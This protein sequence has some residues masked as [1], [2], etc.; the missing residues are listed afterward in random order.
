MNPATTGRKLHAKNWNIE[1]IGD[2]RSQLA[3]NMS[4]GATLGSGYRHQ[5]LKERVEADII[6]DELL[7]N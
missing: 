3:R 6:A 2:I 5:N 7:K 4:T 1:T